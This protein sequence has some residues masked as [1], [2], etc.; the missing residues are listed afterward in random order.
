M[1]AQPDPPGHHAHASGA[2]SHHAAEHRAERRDPA[3]F[4]VAPDLQADADCHDE[5][6][7]GDR[8]VVARHRST[9]NQP[10]AAHATSATDRP[11]CDARIG[12]VITLIVGCAYESVVSVG[13]SRSDVSSQSASASNTDVHA[14][15]PTGPTFSGWGPE[16]I[17]P[18]RASTS[19]RTAGTTTEIVIGH[20]YLAN[21][22]TTIAYTRTPT[23]ARVASH[24]LGRRGGAVVT[25]TTGSP[26]RCRTASQTSD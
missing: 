14:T 18:G 24:L 13:C 9:R 22:P 4:G 10:S 23:A 17:E 26:P 6:V 5:Q 15:M 3:S 21:P 8:E 7:H 19:T 16:R 25:S 20:E 11:R 12:S 2:G 1:Q